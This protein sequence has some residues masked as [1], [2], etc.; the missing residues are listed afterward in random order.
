LSSGSGESALP[1]PPGFSSG[2][3][4]ASL[5][6]GLPGVNYSSYTSKTKM[7]GRASVTVGASRVA[8]IVL[9]LHPVVTVR[10]R[11]VMAAGGS[12][13][14]LSTS[15][16]AQPANGDPSLGRVAVFVTVNGDTPFTL[17]G[18]GAGKYLIGLPSFFGQFASVASVT[19]GG[20]EIRDTGLDTSDGRDI[21]DVVVTL[22]EKSASI[23]GTVHGDAAAG[24]A[25]IV[26]PVDRA[27]WI[28]YGWDPMLIASKAADNN[29]AFVL[30]GL[31]E[32]EYFAVAV[33]GAQHD[34]WT[35]PKFL[36]AASAVAARVTLKWGETKPLDLTLAQVVVK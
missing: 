27:R 24:A 21:D 11:I 20:R 34:A 31:P 18:L 32:G 19:S 16:G 1:E 35:D 17:E 14:R 8:G 4:Q 23:Q 12:G 3:G 22:T 26:F 29:G 5:G 33:T 13:M 30:K 7:G 6:S 15:I 9:S 2:P 28:D 25:V 36:E 10:G